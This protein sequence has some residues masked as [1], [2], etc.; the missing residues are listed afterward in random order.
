MAGVITN[1]NFIH[2]TIDGFA[3]TRQCP[4]IQKSFYLLEC[5]RVSSKGSEPYQLVFSFEKTINE[6]VIIPDLL[7]WT[8]FLSAASTSIYV[9]LYSLYYFFFKTK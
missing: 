1:S 6:L 9:Y 7:Q 5:P 8:S 3:W 4:R 2:F